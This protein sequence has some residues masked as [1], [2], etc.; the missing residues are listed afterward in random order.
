MPP[1]T[2]A[3]KPVNFLSV[4]KLTTPPTASEPYDAEAPPVTTSTR[5]I[6]SCGNWLTSVT[7]VTLAPTT[8]WP[9]SR[10]RVRIGPRPRRLSELRPWMPLLV[11]LVLVVRPVLP[12]SAGS[13]AMVLNT[14]GWAF[15]VR[16]AAL[17]VVVGV[18]WVKPREAMR[19]P[20]TVTT[21]SGVPPAAGASG[22]AGVAA[23]VTLWSAPVC[24]AGAAA[25]WA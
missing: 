18:G 3:L 13:S 25:C 20:D 17:S 12:C 2:L 9:S 22:V 24:G 1:W 16:S 11:L 6:S 10:V 23:G 4:M 21:V 19:E 15:L 5:L 7:P 14:F 8:R